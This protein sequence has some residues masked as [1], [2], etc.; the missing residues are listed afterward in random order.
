MKFCHKNMIGAAMAGL[1]AGVSIAPLQA[2]AQ[3]QQPDSQKSPDSAQSGTATNQSEQLGNFIDSLEQ[4]QDPP[5]A[6]GNKSSSASTEAVAAPSAKADKDN[7]DGSTPQQDNSAAA[8]THQ[9]DPT[10][11][12]GADKP[13]GE[14][15]E[16]IPVHLKSE[17][18]EAAPEEHPPNSR[19]I[20]EIVVTAT[21]REES[22]RDIP[23]SISAFDG[24]ALEN[25]GKLNLFDFIQQT[26]GVT[27]S[28][29]SSG[30]TRVTMRGINTDISPYSGFPST[31]GFFVGD[32]ALNDTYIAGITPDLSA[33]DLSGVQVLKGPQ[34]TLF[35]GAAL[36][37]A[38]RYELQEPKL[39]EWQFRGFSQLNHPQGGSFALTSGAALNIP[40]LKDD[41]LAFRVA[42]I[43]R[44]YPGYTDNLRTGDKDVD[45]S[46]GNQIRAIGLW[47]PSESWKIKL[48]HLGQKTF[49]PWV[50][51]ADN[52]NQHTNSSVVIPEPSR[53]SFDMD[54]LEVG[55]NFDSMRLTSLS[56]RVGKRANFTGDD[57][58]VLFAPPAN[59]PTAGAAPST[60]IDNSTTLN[61]EI[62]LQS[63]GSDPFQWLAGVYVSRYHMH[64][65]I[66]ID[67]VAN[68]QAT[69]AGS[70]AAN[71][72][73][74]LGLPISVVTSNTPLLDGDSIARSRE[75]ALFTDLS[76]KLW[77]RLDLSVGARVYQTQVFGGFVGSG[78]LILAENNGMDSNTEHTLK[79]H[80]VNPKFSATWHFSDDISL[81]A[82]AAKGYRFGGIQDVPSTPTNNVPPTFKSD[83][84]WNYELG[85]RTAWFDNTPQAD[86]T[87]F[88]SQYKNPI[89]PQTQPG[90]PNR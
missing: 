3:T 77:D 61:Q 59:Y 65:N 17:K 55:Y 82:S 37:G 6:D 28:Q 54:A 53:N 57:T 8:S 44:H 2:F 68:Q 89:I 49:A 66:T 88:D 15:L 29:G 33:F 47:E 43:D 75:N 52:P 13:A 83:T 67:T 39:G 35:G 84:L 14:I 81:Y 38:I 64:F 1:A 40:L 56:S 42:Y 4:I 60:V 51:L 7:A 45:H 20:E 32:V 86:L 34:G 73:A 26:P 74:L 27:A 16:T 63:T 41:T 48:T 19:R 78:L 62:R 71:L 69:G 87:V 12:A 85:L 79:E 25:E 11:Q 22:I 70:P 9:D 76:Y 18:R 24:A 58:A 5:A 30:F 10:Q 80:G 72:S 50:L 46:S 23:A 90:L 31:V 21:K 36:S